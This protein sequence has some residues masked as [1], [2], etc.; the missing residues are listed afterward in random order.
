MIES[1]T[2]GN[3]YASPAT[4]TMF[5][6]S[7]W[8]GLRITSCMIS[9]AALTM[10]FCALLMPAARYQVDWLDGPVSNNIVSG[11]ALFKGSFLILMPVAIPFC[12]ANVV[13]LFTS[14]TLPWCTSIDK[15]LIRCFLLGLAFLLAFFESVT[16]NRLL[17]HH[18]WVGS[19]FVAVLAHIAAITDTH[20][21][22][23]MKQNTSHSGPTDT[24]RPTG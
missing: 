18:L 9:I 15:L 19:F 7:E 5:V 13:F 8:S 2:D 22:R 14:V 6:T 10:F 12:M 4:N 23:K 11:W 21:T 20:T 16:N 24:Q 1:S 3:P 17:G